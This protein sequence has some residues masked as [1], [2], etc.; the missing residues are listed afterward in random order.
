MYIRSFL[1]LLL[2][3]LLITFSTAQI[4]QKGRSIPYFSAYASPA[5]WDSYKSDIYQGGE[6][7]FVKSNVDD[8]PVDMT[9]G[10][11]SLVFESTMPS[12]YWNILFRIGWGMPVDYLRMGN[13]ALLHLQLKWE[14]IATGADVEIQVYTQENNVAAGYPEHYAG[15]M[16]SKYTQPSLVWTDVYIPVSDFQAV[17]PQINLSRVTMLRWVGHGIYTT[18]NKMYVEKMEIVPSIENPFVDAVKVNQIGFV[19]DQQK[20]GI[21]SYEKGLS[22]IKPTKYTIVRAKDDSVVFTGTLV[23]K[24]P[25]TVADWGTRRG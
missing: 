7:V 17:N 2:Q 25:Y 13:H 4:T 5:S 6:T 15:V 14:T 12:G 8:V 16:L 23:K 20:I 9:Q 1:V 10:S 11:G 21:V 24:S 19:P 18:V 3:L 22:T